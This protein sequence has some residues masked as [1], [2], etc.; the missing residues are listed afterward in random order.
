MRVSSSGVCTSVMSPPSNRVRSRSS[1]VVNCHGGRSDDSTI[2]LFD[3]YSALNVWK[4]SSWV[5]SLPWRN[6]MSSTM[7]MSRFRYRRLN[8]SRFSSRMELM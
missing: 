7:S 5:D 1:R 4:N 8:A 6:W 3:W 2:C